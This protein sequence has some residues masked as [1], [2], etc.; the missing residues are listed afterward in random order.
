MGG[1]ADFPRICFSHL[2]E[3][4]RV[5]VFCVHLFFE[6]VLSFS[7]NFAVCVVPVFLL[8][9]SGAFLCSVSIQ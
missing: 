6:G 3:G 5:L 7:V 1:W 4:G 2:Y 9:F 8:E